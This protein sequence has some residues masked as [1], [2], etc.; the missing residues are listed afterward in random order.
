MFSSSR[1]EFLKLLGLGAAAPVVMKAASAAPKVWIPGVNI[2]E[3]SAGVRL[4]TA[5]EVAVRQAAAMTE[6][7]AVS[8]NMKA[9]WSQ[10]MFDA[11]KRHWREDA[12]A[13]TGRRL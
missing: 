13:I 10:Q 6:F 5:T 3:V 1:R 8:Q 12:D 2:P 4:S 9:L 11:M 7:G